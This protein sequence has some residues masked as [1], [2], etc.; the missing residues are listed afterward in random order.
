MF[1][2]IV[3]I[4]NTSIMVRIRGRGGR[5][6]RIGMKRMDGQ[7]GGMVSGITIAM[8]SECESRMVEGLQEW[9]VRMDAILGEGDGRSNCT[10]LVTWKCIAR[11]LGRY[12]NPFSVSNTPPLHHT[13]ISSPSKIDNTRKYGTR[14]RS[15]SLHMF[16]SASLRLLLPKANKE[17]L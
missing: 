5:I 4:G 15:D 14:N 3:M 2:M 9:G 10:I 11:V 7:G 12:I 8:E 13:K 16:L 6:D 17:T 1:N